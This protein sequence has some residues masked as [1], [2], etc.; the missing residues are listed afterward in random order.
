[1]DRRDFVKIGAAIGGALVASEALAQG[2]PEKNAGK[3]ARRPGPF[4]GGQPA[5]VTPN[6]AT[7]KLVEK[8]GVKIGH[9]VA[10]PVKHTFTPGLEAECWGY[11]GR[12]HGPTIE[13]VEGDRVRFYVTNRLPEPTTVHWHGVILPCGMDGVAGL[14]QKPIEPKDTHVYEFTFSK[15]GTFMY[16][17]HYDEMT[18]M[19]L[20]MVGMIVVH[21]KNPRGPRVDRDFALV[22]HEW[23]IRAGAR[24]PD[25]NEMKDFNVLTFNAKAYPG[26][27][28]LVVGKGERVRIRLGNL[29]AMD[30]HPI[31]IHGLA[32]ET[33]WT[34]GG[35]IPVTARHPDTT[36]L[37]PTGS[38]RVIEFVPTESGDWAMHCHMTH[39]IMN[40]M[41]HGFP[42]MVGAN[43][44]AIDKRVQALVPDYMTM[45]QAGMGG[46]DDMKMPVPKN[47]IPMRGG[48]GPFS[49]IDMGGMFT[50]L[51]VRDDPDAED[52]KGW[53]AHPKG[54]VAD[55]ADSTKMKADGID[56]D[57][58]F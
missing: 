21:P 43:A 11:N 34:D 19:A 50:I 15:A 6:G 47:S 24:R 45:G 26:T 53:Y 28:P 40:Q 5:V 48:K 51:K 1:M 56:P 27:E 10:M 20:G 16:H 17:P 9:L 41:G 8:D 38:V 31:H 49:T 29:S 14:T 2:A 55:K 7:L 32:F 37:V 23:A 30:H 25:P 13:V 54:T 52:G 12:V 35:E 58:T 36:V 3:R 33:T 46:M 42:V 22:T 18:Q 4:P 44:A 39:H 57:V